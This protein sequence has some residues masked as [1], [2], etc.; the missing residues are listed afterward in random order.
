ML[1][2]QDFLNVGEDVK[3][4]MAFVRSAIFQ[5][6]TTPMYKTAVL[7]DEYERRR[8]R[9]IVNYQKLLYTISGKAIPDNYSANYKLCSNFFG[10]F[11]TQENQYLLGNGVTW[12]N[13]QTEK[14]LGAD[15][16]TRLQEAGKNALIG[17]V[18]F[19][20][21]NLDRLQ[22]FKITEFVPLLDEEDGSI[23]A[24]IRF[25]QIDD[26][27]PLR[28]TFYEMDGYTDFIWNRR[29]T[30]DG[31]TEE[32]GEVLAE[33]RPY[34]LKMRYSE[35][36]GLEIYDGENYP[37]FP[38]VPLWGNPAHQSEIVGLQEAID[39]YDL[40]KS[41]FCNTVDEAS[42]VY[43]TLSNAGAMDDIDLVEFVEHMKT[44]KAAVTDGNAQ[45]HTLEPPHASREVILTRLRNDLY[46][47]AMALDTKQ[48][49]GGA[50][51]ATQIK[52][53]Y[54]PL[55]NK[56]DQFEYCVLDFLKG[57]LAVAGIE[58]NPSFT[59]STIINTAEELSNVLQAAQYLDGEYVTRKLLT[60]MGDGDK[61]DE[62]LKRIDAEN[63]E[64]M[65][66]IMAQQG[67]TP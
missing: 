8:N 23:K 54:E 15:F 47:D 35:A 30:K 26:N 55:N 27:K 19:G 48:I 58:D 11:I 41:G 36:D 46:D 16:D 25:W 56:T 59:R 17:G 45:A 13:K 10:R 22:V 53:A 52:A 14:K 2:F 67:G 7:A 3:N 50:V 38:I 40:I 34:K 29:E 64:R 28:A 24:G 60:I 12:E 44:I 21:F 49:A 43:W 4:I 5:H 63:I 66:M 61:A 6:K 62:V 33:K 1:T 18:A 42:L 39:A 57:I 65:N 51:T 32:Y 31:Q 20:F 37:A 9:T